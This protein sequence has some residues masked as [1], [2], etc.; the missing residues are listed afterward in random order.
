MGTRF[1]GLKSNYNRGWNEDNRKYRNLVY[2]LYLSTCTPQISS[3][4][5]LTPLRDYLDYTGVSH[6]DS[7]VPSRAEFMRKIDQLMKR[8]ETAFQYSQALIE[9]IDLTSLW[10]SKIFSFRPADIM[11][12]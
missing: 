9:S 3:I 2:L 7:D 12:I 11:D 5:Q 1:V 8:L 10:R 6:S 4:H